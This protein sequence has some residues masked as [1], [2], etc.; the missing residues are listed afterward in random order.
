M[1]SCIAETWTKDTFSWIHIIPLV[2]KQLQEKKDKLV[3]RD[4]QL[5]KKKE[6]DCKEWWRKPKSLTHYLFHH[7]K[8]IS[9]SKTSN[10]LSAE[11]ALLPKLF[12]PSNTSSNSANSWWHYF[13]DISTYGFKNFQFCSADILSWPDESYAES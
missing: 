6:K 3:R 12:G 4:E 7:L 8:D 1:Q 2:I 10:G 9:N 13:S 5:K 11:N